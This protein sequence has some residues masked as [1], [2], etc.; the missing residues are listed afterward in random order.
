MCIANSC[1]SC[2]KSCC[3]T[4]SAAVIVPPPSRTGSTKVSSKEHKR[5]SINK[6]RSGVLCLESPLGARHIRPNFF[7]RL[8]LM[9]VFRHFNNVPVTVLTRAQS[10][11]IENL[12]S[13]GQFVHADPETLD[14]FL[15]GTIEY[16]RRTE[17][18]PEKKAPQRAHS[19]PATS[20]AGSFLTSRNARA[21]Q[22][23]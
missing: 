14:M 9:W 10:E 13:E 7:Q 5:M 4:Y 19:A 1:I 11:L 6:L 2:A 18:L 8:R 16:A 22:E 21:M 3:T 17:E 20:G 15:L 12:R 23:R